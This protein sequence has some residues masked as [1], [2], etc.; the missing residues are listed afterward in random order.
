MLIAGDDVTTPD[1]IEV[2]D[3]AAPGVVVGRAAAA[4]PEHV[5][6]AVEAAA[7][8]WPAWAA[9]APQDRAA[10]LVAALDALA[11]SHEERVDVLVR[12]NGKLRFEADIDL[13]VFESRTRLAAGM[14]DDL[15]VQHLPG[16]PMR[17][18]IHSLPLGVVSI[19]VPFNWPAAIL[20]ASMPYALVAGNTVVVKPPPTAP[21]ATVLTLR[22]FARQLPAGVVNVVTGEDAAVAPV[23]THPAV[24]RV[25]FTGSTGAGKRIMSM[26]TENLTRVT[27][28]LGGND[29]AIVLDD[30]GLD[31]A[32]LQR[33]T[34]AS[35]LTSGQVC[36]GVKR[37]YVHRSRYA[38]LVD[39]LT[40]ALA[41]SVVGPGL[42]PSST[43]GPVHTRRQQERLAEYVAQ[44][45]ATGAEVRELGE[46]GAGAHPDGY[47]VRPTLVLD[48]AAD[49]RLVTEE[50]FG[51]V[52]PILP[53]DDLEPL[54][55][56]LNG[57]WSG[58]CSSVWTSDAERADRV[59]RTLR[60][61]TTWVNNANAVA[62]DDRA[63][64]GGFRRSGI[65]REL[66]REGLREFTEPHTITYPS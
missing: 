6:A 57:E 36:M 39:G 45:A 29:P 1:S 14:T 59:A 27:L 40:A 9:L 19:V 11:A 38:E 5:A 64:F 41:T 49:A 4:T 43:M 7:G 25:V 63:P 13:R 46:L 20:A 26:A 53:F 15:A 65:G 61:G 3:P 42:D 23:I 30:A 62:E 16:P 54:V 47:F 31:E 2:R 10:Q 58:L 32:A 18:E 28:E 51:P 33:L 21:L 60:T 52:L 44:A 50:Q 56:Q 55:E 48:P 35:F 17:S 24:Q 34:V 8:A 66:G 22:H 37:I 12:E